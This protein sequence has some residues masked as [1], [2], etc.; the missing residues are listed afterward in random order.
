MLAETGTHGP[1]CSA[2]CSLTVCDLAQ[3]H[4]ARACIPK[5]LQRQDTLCTTAHYRFM[6]W[7]QDGL[8][9]VSHISKGRISS[10]VSDERAVCHKQQQGMSCFSGSRMYLHG[11]ASHL[12]STAFGLSHRH[13]PTSE[14]PAIRKDGMAATRAMLSSLAFRIWSISS[15]ALSVSTLSFCTYRHGHLPYSGS[16]GS[17]TTRSRYRVFCMDKARTSC[18][19]RSCSS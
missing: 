6:L 11:S 15:I 2:Q 16:A 17:H 8:L 1:A 14:M 10:N 7:A 9:A 5:Q 4:F 13:K 19:L 3:Q 18:N 12:G